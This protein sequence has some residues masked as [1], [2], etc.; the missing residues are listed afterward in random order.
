MLTEQLQVL[1]NLLNNLSHF[2]CLCQGAMTS[3]VQNKLHGTALPQRD[4]HTPPASMMRRFGQ[5]EAC[6]QTDRTD[7]S[8]DLPVGA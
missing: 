2:R 4:V 7:R 8:T 5:L 6:G 1:L 3:I